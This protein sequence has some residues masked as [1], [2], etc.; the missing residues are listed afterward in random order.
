M[1]LI[2]KLFSYLAVLICTALISA[3][4]GGGDSSVTTIT[5]RGLNSFGS[6][7]AVWLPS[8]LGSYTSTNAFI[9]KPNNLEVY[10]DGGPNTFSLANV[11][12]LFANVTVCEVA[13]TDKCQEI[14]HVLVDTGSVGL[15]VLASKVSQ[16]NLVPDPATGNILE[17]YPFV[18]G[19]LWGPTVFANVSLG[20][21]R[22]KP[23]PVQLIQDNNSAGVIQ[24]PSDCVLAADRKLLSSASDLGANGILGIGNT[25]LDCGQLCI[26]GTYS[27][28]LISYVPYW[29]CPANATSTTQCTSTKVDVQHQV[30]NPVAALSKDSNSVA[31]DNGVVLLLPSVTGLGA[32]QVHGELIFGIGTR[33]NNQIAAGASRVRLGVDFDNNKKSYLNV[34]TTYN[35]SIIYNSYLDTGTNGFFFSNKTINNCTGSTWYCQ[36]NLPTQIAVISDGDT[37]PFQ[38]LP[39]NVKFNVANANTL[40]STTNA[41]FGDLA[42][43]PPGNLVAG[44]LSFSWGLPFF[45]GKRVALS[46]WKKAGALDGP[47][48]SWSSL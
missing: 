11:N 10:V 19:G 4:G 22:T 37:L 16:L 32:S 1:T 27:Q 23:L 5:G 31:D 28:S 38:N 46:V 2:K 20:L 35:N 3:C 14:D 15:R 18:I 6:S 24:A 33:S 36:D 29:S 48:Y 25:E 34:T 41:A 12:M 30:F 13:N 7:P 42:G 40:F 45:Y 9:Q 21:Q 47:W 26:D 44:E 17:C 39:V 43:A 8:T